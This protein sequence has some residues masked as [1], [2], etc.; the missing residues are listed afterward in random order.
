ALGVIAGVA[1]V[2]L[3][4]LPFLLAALLGGLFVVLAAADRTRAW[5]FLLVALPWAWDFVNPAAGFGIQLPTEPGIILLVAAWAYADA[6]RGRIDAP[7]RV[8]AAPMIATLAWIVISS[9]GTTDP[10]HSAFQ[11]VA[12]TGFVL[13]GAFYP[14]CEI[15]RLETLERVMTIFLVSGALVSVYGLMQVIGSPYGFDRAGTFMGEGLLYNH[16]PYSAFLGFGLGTGLVYLVWGGRKRASVPV[17]VAT[18]LMT[19]ATIVSLARAAWVAMLAL[20]GVM[21]AARWKRSVKTLALPVLGTGVLLAIVIAASPA[22]EKAVSEYLARAVSPEYGSNVERLNRWL[23]GY[24]MLAANPI[25]GVGPSAYETAYPAY[26]DAGY[27]TGVSDERMGAHS[28]LVRTAAEQGIP[29]LLILTWMLWAFYRTGL[30]LMT[31]GASPRIRR[32]AAAVTAG[33]FTYTVH[34]LFNEYWRLPKIALSLWAYVGV[35]G[36]LERIDAAQRA[37]LQPDPLSPETVL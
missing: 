29:G 32:L 7:P 16:G 11:I 1:A 13:G 18:A 15:R 8:L 19:L 37:G 14:M 27:V 4:Q 5:L 30:R 3:V 21:V 23:A 35:L 10:K 20:L 33:V 12:T 26:R 9:T 2:V 24:R 22:T 28:D 31:S 17:A 34:G 6:L 36:A 25:L